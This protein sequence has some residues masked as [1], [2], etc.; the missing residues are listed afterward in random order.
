MDGQ[1]REQ[2]KD[3]VARSTHQSVRGKRKLD[4]KTGFD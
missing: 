2:V 4:M 3:K 1:D